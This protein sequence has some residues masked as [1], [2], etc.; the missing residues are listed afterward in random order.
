MDIKQNIAK[1]IAA[2]VGADAAELCEWLETPPNPDMGDVAF[3][4]F[5]LAKTMRKAPNMIAASLAPALGE[6]DGISRIEP[7]GGYINFFADKTSF[8]R[9][10]LERVL[11]EGARYGGSDI[12]SGKT[13]CLDYSSINIAKPFHIGH[14][15][16]TAIGNALRRIYDHLGYKTVSINHL[17]DWGTQFGKMI[18]AYKLW[19]DKE[20][21]EKGGVRAMMQLYVRFHD[22][23][24]KDDSLNDSARAW[25]K[26]IEQH[27]P[28]AVEIFEWFK[29]ITLKEVGK[30]YDLLGI[31]FDSYAG[32]SFYE[33]KMQPVIDELR[34]KHL[35]RVDNGASIVDL[36]EYSMPPCLILRSD[37]AT[38][39]ATRDLA[40]AIYR[41]N[42]YDFDKLLYVVAYQQSLHFKQIFKVLELMGKDWVK[43][44]V[45]VSFGMVSL[46]DGTL[47]TRHGRV[48]FLEDVLNA[49]IEKT[50]DVIKE[51][52]PDLEDKETV[53][54]QIGVGAVVWGVVYNGRIKDIVFSWDKALNFDGET[55]PYAQYTHARCCS[56][57]RKAGG[58][59]RAKIDYSALSDEA[60]SALVKAIAEFPAAVSEAAEKYEPY[61]ISRSVINV[62]SCFNKFYYDNRIMDENE[63]VR[64]ARLALTDA[65]RNVIK[66]G[67]YLVGLE[68]PEKM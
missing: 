31:K 54:R 34:E 67:L 33:D 27:D 2:N 56:V 7:M 45:H 16:T 21:V 36:S 44:C 22:E 25:F 4:C 63:G 38:L 5:K 24:E 10:T 52:S 6:I 8:A 32:E 15:S 13:V 64:N 9:T 68:A 19:G 41:K 62:C 65:A 18:L 50:L 30:T 46:T 58:Y 35:L 59:D 40:A 12:G 51:K 28:E 61:I 37:G 57:L 53:A 14:L 47:S 55:G 43:D 48:V 42:T 23:A 39:Y 49:A 20:T 66:T 1:T 3:P 26:R 60:S 11:D 29:A 17:G